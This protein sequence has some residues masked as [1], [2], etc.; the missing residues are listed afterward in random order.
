MPERD[1]DALI[2]VLARRALTRGDATILHVHFAAAVVQ[3]YRESNGFSVIRTNTVGRVKKQGGWT[4]DV[5]ISPDEATVHA[6][7]ADL[8]NLPEAEREH[9]AAHAVDLPSSAM[10]ISMRMTPNSCFD[11]GDLRA[12]E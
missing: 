3:R 9:W 11:D 6:V 4:L 5:G 8:L 10:F 12:W 7:F 1:D 2:Q